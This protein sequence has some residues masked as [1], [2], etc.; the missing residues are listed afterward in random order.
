MF[1]IKA[2]NPAG[3]PPL[4]TLGII[5]AT[6]L[7]VPVA[8][9]SAGELVR[10]GVAMLFLWLFGPGVEVGLGR[11]PFGALYVAAGLAALAFQAA[12]GSG[13]ASAVTAVAAAVT[14][15]V[16]AHLV[17]RPAGRILTI[18]VVPVFFGVIAVPVF[19]MSAVWIM[20]LVAPAAV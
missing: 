8:G 19:V 10:I 7:A 16:A 11:L 9:G 6:V 20:V 4:V 17:L 12:V 1:P 5:L 3:R 14:V 18:S 15:T 13:A 2:D